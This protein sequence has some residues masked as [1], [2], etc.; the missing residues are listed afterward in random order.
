MKFQWSIQSR[1]TQ[2]ALDHMTHLNY[3]SMHIWPSTWLDNITW[4]FTFDSIFIYFFI[5][6]SHSIRSFWSFWNNYISLWEWLLIFHLDGIAFGF[7]KNHILY[8]WLLSI[9]PSRI[10]VCSTSFCSSITLYIW[11]ALFS[12]NKNKEWEDI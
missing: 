8:F 4:S 12:K 10:L 1:H 3:R 2:L 11:R 7:L 5:F 6:F 9:F